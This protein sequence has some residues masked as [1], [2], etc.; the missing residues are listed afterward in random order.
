MFTLNIKEDNRKWFILIS[1]CLAVFCVSFISTGVMNALPVIG[2]Q[3]KISPNALQW[4]VTGYTLATCALILFAGKLGDHVDLRLTFYIGAIV[5]IIGSLFIAFGESSSIFLT[6]RVIQGA[7]AAFITPFTL[8]IIKLNFSEPSKAKF[9][10]AIWSAIVSLGFALGPIITG[11]LTSLITWRITF[12][13]G[14]III[15]LSALLLSVIR[16]KQAFHF[17]K[18][19]LRMDY[20]GLLFFIVGIV[21]VILGLVK[22]NDWGWNTGLPWYMIIGGIILLCIFI[23]IETKVKDPALHLHFFK[24]RCFSAALFSEALFI[25]IML[26]LMFFFNI[27]IETPTLLGYSALLAGVAFL[28]AAA[29]IFILSLAAP[30][31]ME[32][33]GHKWGCVLGFLL[34][35]IGTF[36]LFRVT[37]HT[38]YSEIWLPL[39]LAGAG[40]GLLFPTI[41]HIC[42]SAL[43]AE[44]TGEGAGLVS[45]MMYAGATIGTAIAMILFLNAGRHVIHKVLAQTPHASSA[46]Q[47]AVDRTIL[48]HK[49]P[50]QTLLSHL[51]PS[52]QHTIHMIS[53][54]SALSGFSI[55]MLFAFIL[56]VIGLLTCLVAV[57]NNG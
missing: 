5:F 32:R 48:G 14:L 11:I 54:L 50:M 24:N 49:E 6:G 28:P 55:A 19:S 16:R 9:A 46:L 21:G 53:K 1:M 13:I 25:S 34:I 17:T 26:I 18:D 4:A 10:V 42:L 51:N 30:K 27:Y 56:S 12:W 29:G 22:G 43:P 2:Q 39:V 52:M 44:S 57:K 31:I 15:I 35:A 47:T 20:L 37:L 8:S 40:I 45:T 7:G 41:P 3:L 36:L 38:T 33:T 23:V